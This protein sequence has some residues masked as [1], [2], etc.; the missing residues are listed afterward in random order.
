MKPAQFGYLRPADVDAAVAALA[1]HPDAAV[2]AGGQSLMAMLNMRL[3]AP[4]HLIDI[5]R[6]GALRGASLSGDTLRLGALTRHAD[7]IATA[8]VAQAAPMLAK[9]A[10]ALAHPAIRNRGTIGGS[11]ALA[12]PAAELPACVLAL[13]ASIEAAGADGAR[14]IAAADF[15]QGPFETALRP[16][17]LLTAIEIPRPADDAVW[18]YDK[19]ARRNGDYALAGL[20]LT[21]RR[22]GDRLTDLRIAAFGVADRPVL[23]AGAARELASGDIDAAVA[24]LAGDIA[25]VDQPGCSGATK[26]HLTGVLLR[27]AIAGLLAGDAS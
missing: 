19:L 27:R 14:R 11:L 16:G 5:S 3:A 13:D 23:C 4:S 17:E 15:F 20:A 9:A 12:D 7:L 26:L 25:P 8:D 18:S 6:L 2:L 21:G 10:R 24:A 22:A 1:A